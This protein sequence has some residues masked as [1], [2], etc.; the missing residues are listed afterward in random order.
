ML[1]QDFKHLSRRGAYL[2]DAPIG[3]ARAEQPQEGR[4]LDL[5]R[6]RLARERLANGRNGIRGDDGA[7]QLFA[8]LAE[9]PAVVTQHGAAGDG[10]ELRDALSDFGVEPQR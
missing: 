3:V 2:K 9:A 5:A 1:P 8:D 10:E 7:L 4:Q 6:R